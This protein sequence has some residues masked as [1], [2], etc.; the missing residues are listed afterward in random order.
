[1]YGR[2]IANAVILLISLPFMFVLLVIVAF[3]YEILQVA[4]WGPILFWVLVL[5]L[6]IFLGKR[7]N[8]KERDELIDYYIPETERRDIPKNPC[9]KHLYCLSANI[10]CGTCARTKKT[11]APVFEGKYGPEHDN[12][13]NMQEPRHR[14][15]LSVEKMKE[16]TEEL[17]QLRRGHEE[18]SPEK[19]DF[20]S[21]TELSIKKITRC[22]ECPGFEKKRGKFG[23]CRFFNID[24]SSNHLACETM[25]NHVNIN[26]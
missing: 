23:Y 3:F 6:A 10:L 7:L 26:D 21:F 19:E 24:I 17:G 22:H 25:R 15:P 12:L 8:H 16:P 20:V 4:G 1:M 14:P 9:E 5:A 2:R 13:Y 11:G 18:N